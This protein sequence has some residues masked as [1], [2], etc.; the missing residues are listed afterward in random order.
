MKDSTL[1]IKMNR[2]LKDLITGI[3]AEKGMTTSE[4][5]RHVIDVGMAEL[6]RRNLALRQIGLQLCQ[7]KETQGGEQE[8]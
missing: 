6:Y 7:K 1:V 5:T 2:E 8:A 3:A 4:Y